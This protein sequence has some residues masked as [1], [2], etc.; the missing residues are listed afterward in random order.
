MRAKCARLC[1]VRGIELERRRGRG[2]G[3][4]EQYSEVSGPGMNWP[5]IPAGVPVKPAEKTT[6]YPS[7]ELFLK[8][9]F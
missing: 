2:T 3:S 8:N 5:E 7:T 1:C 9:F 4:E 6:L